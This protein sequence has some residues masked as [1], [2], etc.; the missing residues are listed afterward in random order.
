MKDEQ[1]YT[2]QEVA[3]KL[4]FTRRQLEYWAEV[5]LVAPSHR[6]L[7]GGHRYSEEDL[8]KLRL[9]KRLLKHVSVRQVQK[10]LPTL[11]EVIENGV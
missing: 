9:V 11:I 5:G 6:T 3:D 7:G 4:G 1:I 10:L 2:R 8:W